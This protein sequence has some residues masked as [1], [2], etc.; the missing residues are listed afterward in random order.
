LTEPVRKKGYLMKKV[1]I[2][3]TLIFI[4]I[5]LIILPNVIGVGVQKIYFKNGNIKSEISWKKGKKH[6]VTTKYFKDGNIKEERYYNNGFLEG[7]RRTFYKN[8]NP[9]GEWNYANGRLNGDVRYYSKD[10]K[11]ILEERFKNGKVLDKNGNLFS[12][13]YKQYYD[14]GTIKSETMYNN[15]E[16]SGLQKEYYLNGNLKKEWEYP[17][18]KITLYK[19]YNDDGSLMSAYNKLQLEALN[20][21]NEA[22]D[23]YDNGGDLEKALALINESLKVDPS[24]ATS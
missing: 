24:N 13:A 20:K 15:G 9:E 17:K 16:V 3:L 4:A 1:G 18:D 12:G 8:G 21:N 5:I 2:V 22:Y 19:K 11:I 23:L 6:G 7:V 14:D 10:R